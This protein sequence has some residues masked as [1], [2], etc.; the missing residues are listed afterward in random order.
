MSTTKSCPTMGDAV[1]INCLFSKPEVDRVADE[2]LIENKM[3]QT[4]T[5][6]KYK[7]YFKQ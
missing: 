2:K 4:D 3:N 1:P 7:T 5:R 6:E